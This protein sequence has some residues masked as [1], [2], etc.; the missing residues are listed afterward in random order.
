MLATVKIHDIP[1]IHVLYRSSLERTGPKSEQYE[2]L[3]VSIDHDSVLSIRDIIPESWQTESI[4]VV[5]LCKRL[6]ISIDTEAIWE[7]SMGGDQC[8]AWYFVHNDD[9]D[10]YL[11]YYEEYQHIIHIYHGNNATVP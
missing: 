3:Q 6:H 4:A 9:G 5:E 7:D 10:F 8:N 11:G 2:I 1:D